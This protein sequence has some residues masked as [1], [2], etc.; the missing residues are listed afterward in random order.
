M[1]SI[2][3]IGDLCVVVVGIVIEGVPVF[4]FVEEVIIVFVIESSSRAPER[5]LIVQFLCNNFAV[6]SL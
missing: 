5:L 2:V 3:N 4:V 6:T 1:L